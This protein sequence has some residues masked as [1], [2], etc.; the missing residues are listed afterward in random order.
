MQTIHDK[1]AGLLVKKHPAAKTHSAD[2]GV[3]NMFLRRFFH[4]GEHILSKVSFLS[5]TIQSVVNQE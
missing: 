4:D 3:F 1:T 2:N 5:I